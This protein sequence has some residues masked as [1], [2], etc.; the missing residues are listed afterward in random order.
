M[1]EI[2]FDHERLGTLTLAYL[3]S[4]VRWTINCNERPLRFKTLN[5]AKNARRNTVAAL[6]MDHEGYHS[7][8]KEERIDPLVK[9]VPVA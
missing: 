1:F 2:T 5:R 7:E 4:H 3:G 8:A 6:S 9:I